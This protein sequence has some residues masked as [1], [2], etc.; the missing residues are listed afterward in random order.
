MRTTHPLPL[1][2]IVVSL[3]A[4]AMGCGDS[5]RRASP[6]RT[7][8]LPGGGSFAGGKILNTY[9][10]V[11]GQGVLL[12]DGGLRTLTFIDWAERG[13]RQARAE[14]LDRKATIQRLRQP[15]VTLEAMPRGMSTLEKIIGE[16][17]DELATAC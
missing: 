15:P 4:S 11:R 9:W 16:L 12:V 5:L 14:G 10:E 2:A 17:W 1:I 8:A 13:V 6:I 7:Q 3:A